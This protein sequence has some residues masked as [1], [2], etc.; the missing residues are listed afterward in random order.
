[1]NL[2]I[3]I[4]GHVYTHVHNNAL[5]IR[6]YYK[7]HMIIFNIHVCVKIKLGVQVHLIDC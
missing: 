3:Y 4:L 2:Y 5:V 7:L 6:E 1:M